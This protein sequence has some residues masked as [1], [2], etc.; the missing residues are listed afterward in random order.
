MGGW[1]IALW[2]LVV[3]LV[4]GFL[5]LVRGVLLP[6]IVGGLIAILLDPLIRTLRKRGLSRGVAIGFVFTLFFG[7]IIAVGAI[8]LP[9]MSRQLVAFSNNLSSM[10]RQMAAQSYANNY[11]LRWNPKHRISVSSQVNPLD[12]TLTQFRPTLERFGL[13][14]SQ[15][16]IVEQYVE[17]RRQEITKVVQGFFNSLLGAVG[18]LT[19]QVM[20]LLFAPL[21]ALF[22]L[23]DFDRLKVT[24]PS[25]IPPSFRRPV[26][27]V[28]QDVGE[29]FQKYLRG[30]MISWTLYTTVVAIA[31]S[32]LQAPYSVLLALLFGTLYLIPIIGGF[33]N[34]VLLFLI[35][36]LSGTSS[37]WFMQFPSAWTFALV[38]VVVQF[39]ITM[40]WDQV[41]S[42]NLVGSSVGLSPA[43]AM[44]VVAAGGS[45]FGILGMLVAFPIGGAVKV[46]LERAM[47]VATTTGS[48]TLG[49]PAVPLRH[50]APLDG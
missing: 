9:I 37:N 47:R 23:M 46:I 38:L 27:D 28:M 12:R 8:T 19:T 44:F 1:K 11:F 34:Y 32:I 26:M 31:L 18:G 21:V 48:D 29:I 33:L 2:V 35:V 41:V 17:P 6:F 43:V 39:L 25:W 4:F 50:R 40:V 45:L 49:L 15:A 14:T 36:G 42:P 7:L 10:T 20:L 24:S 16:A 13:P 30:I 22:L 3:A 5:Y